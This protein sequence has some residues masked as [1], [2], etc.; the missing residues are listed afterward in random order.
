MS[1]NEYQCPICCHKNRIG[2]L[3]CE[4]CGQ[5]VLD[6]TVISTRI[7]E[8]IHP[9]PAPQTGLL[10]TYQVEE[11]AI[12]LQIEGT[13]PISIQADKPVTLGRDSSRHPRRPDVD[14][15]AFKAF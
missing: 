6:I 7:M 8:A 15:T 14:L 4:N 5:N 10:T 9:E 12:I 3:I 2:V 13:E 11:A 1:V